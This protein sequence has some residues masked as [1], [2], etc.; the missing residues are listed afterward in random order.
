VMCSSVKERSVNRLA[1]VVNAVPIGNLLV[2]VE[3]RTGS[4]SS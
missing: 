3:E 1:D 4:D 2:D